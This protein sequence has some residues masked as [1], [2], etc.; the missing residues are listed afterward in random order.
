MGRISAAPPH[1][2]RFPEITAPLARVDMFAQP[3][4]DACWLCMRQLSSGLLLGVLL[5]LVG[6]D[7]AEG[8]DPV[9]ARILSQYLAE[10]PGLPA[11]HGDWHRSNLP[12]L[13]DYGAQFLAMHGHMAMAYDQWRAERGY[14]PT[15]AWDPALPI[16]ASAP[17]PGRATSNPA[18]ICENCITPTWFTLEGGAS[19]DPHSGAKRLADFQS[20]DQLG[21]S[22]NAPGA[23]AWHTS[24]HTAVGGDMD[25]NST[26]ALDPAFWLF[27]RTIDNIFRSWL[28]VKGAPYPPGV[29]NH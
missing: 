21:R 15:P 27:H 23:P 25:D 17:H 13:P 18:G 24:V 3:R 19:V 16:P 7:S 4:R 8:V 11:G 5:S 9:E 20:A 22:I 26:A 1:K 14:E 10:Y 29:H 28:D 12:G 6:C 2:V